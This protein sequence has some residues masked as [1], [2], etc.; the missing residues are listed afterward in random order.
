LEWL[1][2]WGWGIPFSRRLDVSFERGEGGGVGEWG[3]LQPAALLVVQTG[4]K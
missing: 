3:S 2:G 1:R 4:I